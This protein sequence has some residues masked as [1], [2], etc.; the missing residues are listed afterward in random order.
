M[1]SFQGVRSSLLPLQDTDLGTAQLR[2]EA[3]GEWVR[4]AE[5]DGYE[6]PPRAS[7][8]EAIRNVLVA[9]NDGEFPTWRL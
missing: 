2:I 3:P 8:P 5:S 9:M 1:V 6:L 4:I 7:L